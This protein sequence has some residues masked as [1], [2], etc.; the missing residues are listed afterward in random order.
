MT[1]DELRTD[2]DTIKRALQRERKM[3]ERVPKGKAQDDGL[4]E[5]DQCLAA[6]VRI[7]DQAKHC[8]LT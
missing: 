4:A 3:R 8:T 6:L 7:K 1:L 2:F 5:I